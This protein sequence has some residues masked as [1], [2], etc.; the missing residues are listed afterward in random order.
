MQ[1]FNNLAMIS[2]AH[3]KL[4]R[5]LRH[6]KY[7]DHHQLFLVEG[8]KMVQEMLGSKGQ[9]G[10]MVQEVFATGDWIEAHDRWIRGID[11][12]LNETTLPE[13]KKVSNLVTPQ[14]VLALVGIPETILEPGALLEELVLGLESVRDPGNLGTIVRTAD[15]FGIRHI[16]CTPDSVDLFN[17]KV[18]QATMGSIARVKVYYEDPEVLLNE[19]SLKEKPVC[20]TSLQGENIYDTVLPEH[21]LVL[22]GNESKGLSSRFDPFMGT[23][24]FIPSF[25]GGQPG[26]ESLNLASSVAV[27]CSEFRRRA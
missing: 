16:L 9:S 11:A 25:A 20:G 4:I 7:R 13:L 5:S 15:W 17:P 27:V 6:K 8:E 21:P 19:S 12:G 3:S 24:L 26:S 1:I 14:P 23:R 10:F 2:S 18:V 22:F